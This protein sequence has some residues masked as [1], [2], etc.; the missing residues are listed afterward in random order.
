M[1]ARRDLLRACAATPLAAA[2][3]YLPNCAANDRLAFRILRHDSVIGSHVLQFAAQED[4]VDIH[5]AVDIAV[6]FG[7]ITLYRYSLRGLEQ[8]RGGSVSHV[9]ATADNNGKKASM[10]CDRDQSGL[11]AWG[12]KVSR[13]LTPPGALPASHWNMAELDGPW[14]NFEDGKLLHPVVSARGVE[15][16]SLADGRKVPARHFVMSGDV[17]MELWYD[18]A[19]R[20]TALN[21]TADDG[22]IIRY[23]R[24]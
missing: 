19:R 13:Y 17:K 24:L 12:T 4:G 18:D 1:I 10:G 2:A 21:F 16:V 11:W 23:E 3:P 7:P 8:W 6:S 15:P 5:I 9:A 14:I 22:S 20:W